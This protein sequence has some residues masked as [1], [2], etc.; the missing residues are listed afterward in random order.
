MVKD[1]FQNYF[2]ENEQL[3]SK[4]YPGLNPRILI[5]TFCEY[6]KTSPE[7]AMILDLKHPF[8]KKLE[9]GIPL[10]YITNESFFFNS[11]F[12]V[13][14]SVL[15][16][17][18]ETEVLVEK[19]LELVNAK[20]IKSIADVGCGSGCVAIS[21]L[22]ES[23]TPLK[24][25]ATEISSQA[26][27]VA[28]INLFRHKSRMPSGSS[29]SLLEGDR[30][31][32]LRESVDM[33]VSNPPYIDNVEGKTGVHHQ[34]DAF[35]PELALYIKHEEYE[36]WFEEFFK[37]VVEKLNPGGVFLMEGHEDKLE[38]QR[39]MAL[40]YFKKAQTLN[41]LTGA[42]RFLLAFKE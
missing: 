19:A 4:N 31:K 17:R 18:D 41:D 35:E 6:F 40:R 37:Q 1:F 42:T 2:K 32:P 14:P 15:I 36:H 7:K 27:E 28:K 33:V 38:A 39:Q 22:S 10:E 34:A 26:L 9:E 3:L 21:I 25:Y 5:N 16:P 8:F 24:A 11:L 13:N 12:Y 23:S 29:L 20:Q 30:L